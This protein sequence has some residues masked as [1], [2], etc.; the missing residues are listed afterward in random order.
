MCIRDRTKLIFPSGEMTKDDARLLLDMAIELR[1][2]VLLQL[3]AMNS[4]EFPTTELAYIDKETGEQHTVR[5]TN[6][7]GELA[8]EF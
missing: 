7:S 5:I 2:R 6:E 4:Q 8:E 3:H 1:L